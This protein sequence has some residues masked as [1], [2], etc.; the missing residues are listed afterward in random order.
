MAYFD[1]PSLRCLL[2]IFNPVTER[3]KN[4]NLA[5]IVLASLNICSVF[6]MCAASQSVSQ[7]LASNRKTSTVVSETK[8]SKHHGSTGGKTGGNLA[9]HSGESNSQVR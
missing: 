1:F 2:L 8:T 9:G 4:T 6:E 3:Q 5:L 7:S